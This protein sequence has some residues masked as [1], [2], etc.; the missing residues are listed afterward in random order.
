VQAAATNIS[1]GI[2]GDPG[3]RNVPEVFDNRVARIWLARKPVKTSPGSPVQGHFHSMLRDSR[4]KA[5]LLPVLFWIFEAPIAQ[6]FLPPYYP[7]Q[8]SA[9]RSLLSRTQQN[10]LVL[11]DQKPFPTMIN[12]PSATLPCPDIH[13]DVSL[14]SYVTEGEVM[15]WVEYVKM[16]ARCVCVHKKTYRRDSN[17]LI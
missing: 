17:K 5:L 7:S 12:S 2:K 9:C 4:A 16:V 8:R 14:P 15:G 13:E 11:S 6:G 3:Q 1:W 10:R